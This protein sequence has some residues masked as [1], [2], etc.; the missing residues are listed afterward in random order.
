MALVFSSPSS[1]STPSLLPFS[2]P[3][4]TSSCRCSQFRPITASQVCLTS[5]PHDTIDKSS[6][7]ISETE[8]EDE[9]WAASCLRV[10]SFFKSFEDSSSVRIQDHKKYLAELEFEAVQERIA[11]KRIGFRRVSCIN[12]TLPLSQLSGDDLCAECKYTANGED[13][14]VVGTLD[15]NQ[16]LRLPNE[17][18]GK[19]PEGTG[20][21]ILRAY[22]SNVCVAKELHRQG[23]AYKLVAKSKLVAQQ[24]GITDVYVHVAVDNEPARKLYMKSG[25]V[26]EKDE[27][28]WHARLLDRPRLLLLWFGL[29]ATHDSE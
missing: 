12:A 1:S 29:A 10:R 24:W 22:L 7:L 19:K 9:L 11:G 3:P 4:I 27:P 8:A 23:L 17:M 18:I 25:F 2:W 6:L 15:L 5:P 20:S 13:R 21:D 26:F 16:C 14:V 28:V